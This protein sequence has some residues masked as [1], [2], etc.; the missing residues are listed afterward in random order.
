MLKSGAFGCMIKGVTLSLLL[1]NGLFMEEITQ[2]F[3]FLIPH[4]YVWLYFQF[5]NHN[6]K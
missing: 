6:I 1:P 5:G 2:L 3:P 4:A